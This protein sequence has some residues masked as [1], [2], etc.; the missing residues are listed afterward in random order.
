MDISVIFFFKK[1]LADTC[2]FLE[3][4]SNTLFCLQCENMSKSNDANS[5]QHEEFENMLLVAHYYTTRSA[6][7]GHKSLESVAAKLSV[8][9]LRHTHIV[10]AD[11]AFFEAG[12]MTKVLN[13]QKS[14]S[15]MYFQ[16]SKYIALIY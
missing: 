3:S 9:L 4:L 11:K 6:A 2:P 14:C 5:P 13:W 8:S 1:F 16:K 7:M 12:V 15:F 10:P